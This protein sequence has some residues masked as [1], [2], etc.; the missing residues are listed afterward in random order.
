MDLNELASHLCVVVTLNVLER[1][2]SLIILPL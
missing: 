1:V 2:P